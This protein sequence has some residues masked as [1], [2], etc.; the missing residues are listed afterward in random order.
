MDFG[1]TPTYSLGNRLWI[2]NGAGGGAANDG[3]LNGTEP[4]VQAGVTVE[5][6]DGTASTVVATTT[7]DANGYYRF[8]QL[9]GGNYVVRIADANFIVGGGL[10]GYLPSVGYFADVSSSGPTANNHNHG[11]SSNGHVVSAT[12]TLGL[13]NPTGEVDTVQPTP[14]SNNAPSG[15]ASDNLLVDFGFTP[16]YSLGDYVWF[17]TNQDGI[18]QPDERGIAG[19]AVNLYAADGV[20][21]L[22]TTQTD[23]S[24]NYLF[25][26]LAGGNYVIGFVKPAG[27]QFSPQNQGTGSLQDSFDSDADLTTGK[28][29]V[30]ALSGARSPTNDAGLY[31]S[32]GAKPA[33][34]IDWVWYDTNR[35][36]LQSTGETGL[37]GVTVN[38]WDGGHTKLLASTASDGQGGYE[39]TGLAAGSYTVQFVAPAAYTF[40]AY[41]AGNGSND[42]TDSDAAV[43]TGLTTP[44]TLTA[45][46]NLSTAD[47]GLYLTGTSAGTNAASIGNK[48]WYDSNNNGVQDA[49]EPGIPGVTVYL[50]AA[51]G[52]TWLA[53]AQT[54]ATGAYAFGGL[55]AGA[56][57]L[58]F[59]GYNGLSTFSPQAKGSAIALDSDADPYNGWV[60]GVTVT[61]GQTRTDIDVGMV[62]VNAPPLSAGNSVWLDGDHNLKFTTGEGLANAQVVLYDGFG[63]ELAR[64]STTAA[65]ANYLFAGLGQG[66]YRVEVNKTTLPANAS[67]IADPDAVLD[68]TTDLLNLAT[69]LAT[70]NFG[71]ST[72][73]DFGDL[74]DSYATLLAS[75][76]PRHAISGI[77]LGTGITD[78]ESDGQPVADASGDNTNGATPNDEQGVSMAD[79]WVSG[80]SAIIKVTAS[81]AGVLN[82]WA[83]WNGNGSFETNENFLG[84]QALT[85]GVNSLTVAVPA[86]AAAGQVA[87][88]FRATNAT[89]QGG[90]SPTGLAS[91]GEA[92][93]YFTTLYAPSMVGSIA[94]EV[95]NDSKGDGNLAAGYAGLAG[96]TVALYTDPNG[97]G[98]P[99]DGTLQ[100]SVVTD[101]TG[102]YSFAKLLPGSYVVVETNPVA[103]PAFVSTNDAVGS[104]DDKIPVVLASGNLTVSG[105]DFLD[106]QPQP[107]ASTTGGTGGSSTGTGTGGSGASSNPGN[108]YGPVTSIPL[109]DGVNAQCVGVIN[110]LKDATA[111]QLEGLRDDNDGKLV[112]GFKLHEAKD[113]TENAQ[114]EGVSLNNNQTLILGFGD[115]TQK[116]YS[117]MDGSCQTETYS[118]VTAEGDSSRKIAYTLIGSDET[119][120]QGAQNAIQN[121]T[122]STLKCKVPTSLGKVTSAT[123]AV[124]F[125]RTDATHGDPEAYYDC[126]DK[127]EQVSLLNAADTKFVDDYQ[128]GRTRAPAVALVNPAPTPDPMA[129]A[130]WNSFPSGS[131]FYIV[132]YEDK[133]PNKDDYDFNDAVVA[134]QVQ[135]GLNSNNQVV[136]IVGNAYLIARG[137]A[138][139]HDWH[140]RIGLPGTVKTTVN[141][142]TSL[143]TT[144]QTDLACN[145]NGMTPTVY[146]IQSSGTADVLVFADTL[147]LF[148]NTV[149]TDY[150]KTFSN[151][152][153]GTSYLQGPKSAFSITLDQP[154]DPATIA[155][156]PFDPYL[157]VRNTKQT[158]QLLQVNAAIQDS[159]GY[160]FAMM[161]PNGWRWPYEV[162]SIVTSYPQFTSFIASQGTSSVNWYNAPKTNLVYPLPTGWAW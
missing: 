143:P 27:Y 41:K 42:A 102:M 9:V 81:A 126:T 87:V 60:G 64:L 105:R 83:D 55:A 24:G 120:R 18:Q 15:D 30:V 125:L 88:R 141:C 34:I 14:A 96:A 132:A 77:Y 153:F 65:N 121:G 31:S 7:T 95:R 47:A 16:A 86:S 1:F 101:T 71:Y 37:A 63:D 124:N 151:T 54:D 70:V 103:T 62:I 11:H 10:L 146:P 84:G 69:S 6:L 5:L 57:N 29:A 58:E 107:P 159:N 89:G 108:S 140:L 85:A 51:D 35:D 13:S 104:N 133:Y 39:F 118:L 48:V 154:I 158:I 17:D 19:V 8:D 131:T 43:A 147:K 56:Y 92:E 148:P 22:Q 79:L 93:D 111:Q 136:K 66:S 75:N 73:I 122:D 152:L 74:P 161:L 3:I 40:T 49:G 119:N 137:A 160:P 149:Y 139:T 50:Y 26:G 157:Y 156:A 12:V 134:Y 4:P 91:N 82:A 78:A 113:G 20:T 52:V 59:I 45:G 106:N 112:F 53:E 110:L 117:I 25:E 23:G 2:D 144:P 98:N 114:S 32:N 150:R 116:S 94:G 44:V 115:G 90:E 61:A 80:Q 21:L 127:G 142:T 97:D 67:E 68:S 128:A 46:Q 38:L 76:G 129:V 72:L 162:T 130:S 135:F 109:T 99:A 145:A 100:N 33:N 36:G 123:L 155:V 28:T 138:Y